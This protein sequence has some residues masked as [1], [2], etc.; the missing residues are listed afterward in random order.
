MAIHSVGVVNFV[1]MPAKNN[2]T[3]NSTTAST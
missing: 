3:A 1:L 2:A